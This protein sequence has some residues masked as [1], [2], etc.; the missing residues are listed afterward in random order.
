MS[1]LT[2]SMCWELL[3][4]GKDSVNGV[5]AAVYQKPTSNDCYESRTKN[6]PP[7]CEESDN[8]NAAW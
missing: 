5:S 4:I 8:P 7:L 3:K 1:K 2:K 6:D